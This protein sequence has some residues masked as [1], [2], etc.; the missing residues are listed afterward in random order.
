M[1]YKALNKKTIKDNFHIPVVE[2]LLDKLHGSQYFSKLDL[3]SSY[4]QK[5]M[6][7]EDIHK[8]TFRT[9]EEHYEFLVIPFSLTNTP[10]NFSRVSES[11]IQAFF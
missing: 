7:L 6:R 5:M 10:F 8:T 4:H 3:W 9:H 2:E 1:D 11:C